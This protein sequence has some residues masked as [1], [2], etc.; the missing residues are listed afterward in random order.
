MKSAW[1][2]FIGVFFSIGFLVIT[3]RVIFATKILINEVMPNPEGEDKD[4]EWLELF[5]PDNNP[6]D[7]NNFI[8][9]DSDNHQITI[10]VTRVDSSTIIPST[11]WLII[12]RSGHSTFSLNNDLDTISLFAPEASESTDVFSYTGSSEGL[13]R[14]RLPNGSSISENNLDPTP[15]FSNQPVTSPSP[16]ANPSPSPSASSGSNQ[17]A[18]SSSPTPVPIQS[19]SPSPTPQPSKIY[20]VKEITLLNLSPEPV[21][22]T[23]SGQTDPDFSANRQ[24]AIILIATGAG[25]L[26]AVTFIIVRSWRKK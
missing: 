19:L 13:S 25:L 11:G 16:G 5:N 15:G 18:A 3:P 4:L 1:L 26:L 22:G 21:L 17:T 12:K 24:V 8:L 20:R 9:K 6:F 14:G 2:V 10:D 23:T 7:V